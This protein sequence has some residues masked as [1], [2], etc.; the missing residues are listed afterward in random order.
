MDIFQGV[1]EDAVLVQ[2]TS[3]EIEDFKFPNRIRK[4][5]LCNAYHIALEIMGR[6]ITNTIMLG[7]LVKTTGVVSLTSLLSAL[8]ETAFRDAALS[9]NV[10]AVNRGFTETDVFELERLK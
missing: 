8:G 9:K 7:A 6:P 5:G 10:D 2:A 3:K 4:V 1:K